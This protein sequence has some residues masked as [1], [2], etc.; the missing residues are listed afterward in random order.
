MLVEVERGNPSI[1]S[2]LLRLTLGAGRPGGWRQRLIAWWEDLLHSLSG[3]A[4]SPGRWWPA[5]AV[6]VASYA[7]TMAT[8]F[9]CFQ[10]VGAHVGIAETCFAISGAGIAQILLAAPGGAGVTEASLVAVFMALGQDAA[11]A[12]AGVF[13]TRLINYAVVAVWGGAAFF[14]LQRRYGRPAPIEPIDQASLSST[15]AGR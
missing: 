4:T 11:S 6:S 7:V 2:R 14:M 9:L 8:Y 5:M 3:A 13:L 10:A 15:A 12:A 1:V